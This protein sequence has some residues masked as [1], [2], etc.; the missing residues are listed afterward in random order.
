MQS[1][2]CTDKSL[3]DEN[4]N[5]PPCRRILDFDY[6]HDKLTVKYAGEHSCSIGLKIKPMNLE[7]VKNYFRNHPS[8]TPAMFKDYIIA[9]ALN[10]SADLEEVA[11]QYADIS[12][13][14]NIQALVRRENDPDGSGLNYLERL[15]FSLHNSLTIEDPY[16]LEIFKEPKLMLMLSSNERMALAKLIS[17]P[18]LSTSESVSID[19]CESQIRNYSVMAVTTYSRDLRQLVPLFQFIFQKLG[20][21]AENVEL[22][23]KQIDKN[24][25]DKFGSTFNPQQWT[26]DNSGAIENGII[27]VKGE[28]VKSVLG[29]DKLHDENNISRVLKT[30]PCKEQPAIREEIKAMINGLSSAVSEKI[31]QSLLQKSV[32]CGYER[33]HRSL[34]FNYRKRIKFWKSY[35]EVEDNNCTTEQVNRLQTRHAK[36]ASLMD[37]VGRIVR[38]SIADKAKFKLAQAGSNV[39]KGPTAKDRKTRV[40]HAG[41]KVILHVVDSLEEMI[42]LDSQDSES[43]SDV[44]L[45]KKAL[46]DF[47]SKNCDTHRA[48]K[49]R[50]LRQAKFVKERIYNQKNLNKAKNKL[51]QEKLEVID[52]EESLTDIIITVKN[53]L[54][55]L[56]YTSFSIGGPITC[57]C[58]DHSQS[59]YCVEILFLF[60]VMKLTDLS[61]IKHCK[62]D[63]FKQIKS[64]LGLLGNTT[65]RLNSL[66]VTRAKRKEKCSRCNR[67]VEAKQLYCK[68]S[69]QKFCASRLCILKTYRRDPAKVT[70]TLSEDEKLSLLQNGIKIQ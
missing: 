49:K 51:K 58:P 24:M 61:V 42:S 55:E 44:S 15:R 12:K 36:N 67:I 40:E 34:T 8:S 20:E 27:R 2:Q 23:L 41:N 3:Q 70:V 4:G 32:E 31:Y 14:R 60:K 39:N 28:Q 16:L 45:K 48:D 30:L 33:L 6:C 9:E 22:A 21:S 38:G 17:T 1:V 69:K 26:S 18:E 43:R 56:N 13:I 7:E 62:E 57:T 11:L 59:F 53:Q 66:E 5:S 68:V 10:S 35:R 25:I 47:K 54:G 19:F 50:N 63:Q 46:A 64:K 29:S 37:G 52:K 65:E